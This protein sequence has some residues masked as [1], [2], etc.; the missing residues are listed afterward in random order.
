MGKGMCPRIPVV[1][2]QPCPLGMA[3]GRVLRLHP[4]S[5][6]KGVGIT[7]DRHLAPGPTDLVEMVLILL[8]TEHS[9]KV[10]IS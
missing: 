3:M 5:C 7:T 1:P 9:R 4:A 10:I 8:S 2:E 6:G